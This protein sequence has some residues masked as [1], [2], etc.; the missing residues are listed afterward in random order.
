MSSLRDDSRSRPV[1]K[2]PLSQN[3]KYYP[4]ITKYSDELCSSAVYNDVGVV[5]GHVSGASRERGQG[6]PAVAGALSRP[7]TPRTARQYGIAG[8]KSSSSDERWAGK[9]SSRLGS[10]YNRIL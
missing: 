1:D 5:K 7:L 9:G 2:Q 8:T 6:R 4:S 10:P 3:G